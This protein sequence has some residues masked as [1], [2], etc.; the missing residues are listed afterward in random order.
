MHFFVTGATGFLGSHFVN[1]SLNAGHRVTALRRNGSNPRI[2]L[3]QEPDWCHGNLDDDWSDQMRDCDALIHLAA[4]GVTSGKEDWDYCYRINVSQSLDLWLR[5]VDSGIKH[6][7]I[8]GSCFE[9][10]ITAMNYEYIPV[11]A[12]LL[13]FD[14][15]SA[16]KASATLAAIGIANQLNLKVLVARPFHLY[17]DGEAQTRFWPSLRCAALSG[18]DFPMSEGQQIRDFMNVEDAATLMLT[19]ACSLKNMRANSAIQ[20]IGTGQPKSLLVFAQE[21]WA[22][23]N[24]KGNLLPGK[25]PYRSNEIMRYVPLVV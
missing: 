20:N 14:A 17:G 23:H 12:P 22:L 18:E 4:A 25:I 1:V 11:D 19:L 5:A 2:T 3:T 13:P 15:Y 10:G 7:L 9:Y 21:Q 16:S 8:C 24:A 6:F